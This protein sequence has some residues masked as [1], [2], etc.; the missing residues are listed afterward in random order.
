[1]GRRQLY[2]ERGAVAQSDALRC[3]G[4]AVQLDEMFHDGESKAQ[5]T[6]AADLIAIAL[7][8]RIEH[9]GQDLRSDAATSV[10]D[11]EFNSR[12]SWETVARNASFV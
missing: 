10:R 5:A 8:E 6:V 2:S 11:L 4:T 9:V 1:M 3:H 12:S 7:T